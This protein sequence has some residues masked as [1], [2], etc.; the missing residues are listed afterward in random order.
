MFNAD[1]A[2]AKAFRL[3]LSKATGQVLKSGMNLL[4]IEM[5]TRM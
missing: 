4:G 2:E 3:S 5:P 1:T